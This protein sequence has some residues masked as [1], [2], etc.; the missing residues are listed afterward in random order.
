MS[1][2]NKKSIELLASEPTLVMTDYD[3]ICKEF[4]NVPRLHNMF[5]FFFT[6]ILLA[7]FIVFLSTFTLLRRAT[8]STTKAGIAGQVVQ[9]ATQNTLLIVIAAVCCFV[10]AYGMCQL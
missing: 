6:W 2:D 5:A 4:N 8:S 7:G 10:G 1:M 9:A 3:R